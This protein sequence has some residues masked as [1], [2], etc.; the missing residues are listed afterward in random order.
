MNDASHKAL[1]PAGLRDLLPPEAAHEV[2]A[3]RRLLE[4]FIAQGYELVKPPLLEFEEALL[5]GTGAALRSQTFRLM[6]PV[7]QR[8]MGLRA[9]M[10][11]QIVRM[12]SSRL[13]NAPR[14]LRL[15]YAGQVLQIRGSQLR[16]EREFAQVGLELI[17]APR[18]TGDAEAILLGAG[19]LS[20]VGVREL[21]VDL[22]LPPLITALAEA[23]GFSDGDR[24]KLRHALDGKDA[25]AVQ[26]IAGPKSAP[27]L[28][29][30]RA[31]GPAVEALQA[32][33]DLEL[34]PAAAAGLE[35]LR[36][37][38]TLIGEEMPALTLTV[39]PVEHRGFEYQTGISFIFF[40][41]GVRGELGR[42]G[43]YTTVD[44]GA[45]N[46][47]AGE[48]STGFSLFMDSVLRALPTPATVRRLFLPPGHEASRAEAL[49][50]EGWVTLRGLTASN[51]L[52]E[53]ARR[54][55]CSH[56]LRDGL[57]EALGD[58]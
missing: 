26:A 4:S 41:R 12:A 47:A 14:P 55:G 21:S 25:A 52:A 29:L 20:A 23:L 10:T 50:K 31:A 48:S 37:V 30:L 22:N 36:R 1:L 58:K 44:S 43:R 28:A 51:D 53:E 38:V 13:K 46:P 35:S 32:L 45:G 15:C 9:D 7:S 6:D 5:S 3:L 40:A 2:D 19:A 57:V 39:D 18:D 33:K 34:P 17:A 42:G 8:M 27:F 56:L 54:L 49:R 24:L 11:P 16:P